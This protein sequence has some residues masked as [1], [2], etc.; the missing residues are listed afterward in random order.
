MIFQLITVALIYLGKT[1]LDRAHQKRRMNQDQ[2]GECRMEVMPFGRM[3]WAKSK[4]DFSR[5][6]D[7]IQ[8][9]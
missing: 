7:E 3:R 6:G 5:R 8:R 9:P 2:S 4:N 1:G